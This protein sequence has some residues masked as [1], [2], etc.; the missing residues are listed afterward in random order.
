MKRRLIRL[1]AIF[2]SLAM[3]L[4]VVEPVRA[5][6][7]SDLEKEKEKIEQQKKEAD[8]RKKQEQANYNNASVK[9]DSIQSEVDE[10]TEEIEE[11][12]AA[13]VETLASVE[14]IQEEIADKEDQIEVTTANYEEAQEVEQEQYESMKLRIKFMYEKGDATYLQLLLESGGFGEMVNK[15]E[16]VEKLYEYDRKLLEESR[17]LR[18]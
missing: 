16:Y 7:I 6:T 4:L 2:I 10:I 11:I 12:D 18:V 15:V 1:F 8:E 9:V 5:T 14:M 3:M 17:V 13:L